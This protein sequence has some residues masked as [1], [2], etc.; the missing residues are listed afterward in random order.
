V[1]DGIEVMGSMTE[2]ERHIISLA[3]V[4]TGWRAIY[5]R[6]DEFVARPVTAWALV[7]DENHPTASAQSLVGIVV[8]SGETAFADQV[9]V[10]ECRFCGYV[11]PGD[12]P[13][14]VL[15]QAAEMPATEP[16]ARSRAK[17]FASTWF[18]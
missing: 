5:R 17:I 8:E 3:T 16:A 6:G 1:A 10:D 11:G 18:G 13:L 9:T 4:S 15:R 14:T 12:D 2:S 7:E